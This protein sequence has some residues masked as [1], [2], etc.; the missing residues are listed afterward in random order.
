MPAVE[1][2]MTVEVCL[3]GNKMTG[4]LAQRLSRSTLRLGVY[5]SSNVHPEARL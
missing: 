2:C 4:N 5:S 1:F 3:L